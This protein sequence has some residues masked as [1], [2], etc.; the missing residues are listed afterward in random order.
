MYTFKENA[1]I[2][3]LLENLTIFPIEN[4][5]CLPGTDLKNGFHLIPIDEENNQ[6]NYSHLYR[7]NQKISDLIFRKGGMSIGFKNGFCMLIVYNKIKKTKTNQTGYDQ[8]NFVIIN[9]KVE[10]LLQSGNKLTEYPTY[11]DG[12][13][14]H[15]NDTFYN[16]LTKEI[17]CVGNSKIRTEENL[18]VEIYGNREN[19]YKTTVCQICLKTGE[20]IYHN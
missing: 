2:F 18:F 1:I 5:N 10:I 6:N 12:I 15:M 8:G 14:A 4:K 13:I 19:N 17:I 3:S 11:V 20:T 9:E 16:L 7:N